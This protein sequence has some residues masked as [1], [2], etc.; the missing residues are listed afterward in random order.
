MAATSCRTIDIN[1]AAHWGSR[2]LQSAFDQPQYLSFATDGLPWQR[3]LRWTRPV[4]DKR[5]LAW[6]ILI[7]LVLT[8]LELI[9]F[10]VGMR[11]Q[12]AKEMRPAPAEVLQVFLIPDETNEI[13]AAPP[14]P[15]PP[16]RTV[17]RTTGKARNVAESR[18]EPA[19][20]APAPDALNPQAPV[21]QL[22]SPDGE[23]RLPDNAMSREHEEIGFSARVPAS[24]D[25]FARRNPVPYEPTRFDSVWAPSRE[26]LGQELI[27]KSIATHTWRTPWGTQVTCSVSFILGMLGG[28]GWGYAPTATIDAGRSADA[29]AP[30]RSAAGSGI[31]GRRGRPAIARITNIAVPAAD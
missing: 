18:P 4:P 28:C 27:R 3:S 5:R 13:P 21:L 25:P 9:G 2:P 12:I 22:Y 7:G 31:D 15:E 19:S 11:G 30:A 16:A 29:G 10:G 1:A 8:A 20:R 24:G 14:E 26:T 23:L 17:R 6:A